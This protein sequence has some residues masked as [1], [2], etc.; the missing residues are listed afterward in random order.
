MCD[1]ALEILA[2]CLQKLSFISCNCGWFTL[3]FKVH[4]QICEKLLLASSLPFVCVCR[5]AWNSSSPTGWKFCLIF[6][7]SFEK[8][9]LSLKYDTNNSEHVSNFVRCI[10][11]LTCLQSLLLDFLWGALASYSVGT[12]C[13]LLCV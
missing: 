8:F 11:F 13:F 2:V 6:K 9:Y 5:S 12:L 7:N 10:Q 3:Y 1:K 4:S